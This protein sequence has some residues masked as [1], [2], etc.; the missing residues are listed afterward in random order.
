[1]R[2]P[3]GKRTGNPAVDRLTIVAHDKF[4]DIVDEANRP[5]SA[6]HGTPF[7]VVHIPDQPTQVVTVEPTFISLVTG[8]VGVSLPTQVGAT[9][10]QKP[11]FEPS[12]EQQAATVTL[13]VLRQFEHVRN[14]ADLAR[15]EII[16]QIA[17]R[18]EARMRP[19]QGEL[20]EVAEPVDF[21]AVAQMVVKAQ[22]D[23]T[24]AIPRLRVVP[25]GE[26]SA[27]FRDFDLD[28][29]SINYQSDAQNILI[30]NLTDQQRYLLA[31]TGCTTHEAR[32][33]DYIVRGLMF[34]NDIDYDAHSEL[35]YKLAGQ[36]VRR[37]QSYLPE[38]LAVR[39]VLLQFQKPLCDLVHAQMQAHFEQKAER[40]DVKVSK[41]F[42]VLRGNALAIP[43]GQV[44]R[45]FRTPL[46]NKSAIRDM[47]FTGFTKC[48]YPAQ[49]FQSDPE[50]RFAAILE[51][52]PDVLKWF[53]PG[54]EDLP[55][56]Y[57]ITRNYEPDFVAET[58]AGK[59]ICEVKSTGQTAEE[60]VAKKARAA[61][62]WCANA[63]TV[64]AK[65]W[66]YLLIPHDAVLGNMSMSG[67][68]ARYAQI[69]AEK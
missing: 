54:P 27:G 17:A 12:K 39:N 13:E 9:D 20:P 31:T 32:L 22:D 51:D 34:A 43:Q 6:L 5:E 61:V 38:E 53:K 29:S 33:E 35:L 18:V 56:D 65:P 68:A 11:L 23:L 1:M 47:I 44:M 21:I 36:V 55:I 63:S 58:H 10:Q 59:Y 45:P 48:I 7:E 24:I 19:A 8:R 40:W 14:M 30:Q 64:D 67:L 4:Q 69:A 37:L 49:K 46:D 66:S 62:A 60:V 25:G 16:D 2:L 28:T 52:D 41:G 42:T 26:H 15:P 3:Y 50:R 57:E